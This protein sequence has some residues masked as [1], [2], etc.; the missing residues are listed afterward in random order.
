MPVSLTPLPREIPPPTSPPA[1]D[2]QSVTQPSI[3]RRIRRD[4]LLL[5]AGN[6]AVLIA[7]LG[8]R[9]ILI[10]ALTPADY[11]R[12]ALVLSIYNTV[13]IIGASGLPNSVA[14]YIAMNDSTKDSAIIRSAIL[15]G[16]GPIAAAAVGIACVSGILLH[17]SLAFVFAPIGLSALVYSLLTMG[18][19]R[20]RGR[21]GAAAAIMPIAAVGEVV[22]LTILWLSRAGVTPL[23]AFGVFCL[24]NVVGLIAGIFFTRRTAPHIESG[25]EPSTD[26]VPSPGSLLRFA[27]W[28]GAAT[29]GVAILPVIMRAAAAL[30]SYTVVAIIDV[31]LVLFA[32]PQRLG[33]V[34][35]LAV[36][37]HASRDLDKTGG[38]FVISRREHAI[39]IVPFVI[40]AMIVAFTPIVG[41]LFDALGRPVY[42]RSSDYLALALL[43]GPARILYGVVEGVL[44]AHGEGRFLAITALSIAALASG[45]I[46]AIAAL[47]GTL[48]AFAVFAASFWG[49]YLVG[50]A[51]VRRL[52]NAA[53]A[54]AAMTA[55]NSSSI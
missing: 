38:G 48:L 18:I 20:G 2:A 33:T 27:I 35:V 47:T 39:T 9:S 17:S 1:V 49:V 24:G 36:V 43:A 51:R 22:P 25:T 41:W 29:I 52:T 55:H 53:Q 6:V 50:L 12:L 4:V 16:A 10:T 32:I 8:F 30:D 34:I 40:A 7:Q 45:L 11:G 15:A 14:R 28:L 46:F 21:M 44:V 42:G 5:G 37:P 26:G 23:S 13:W 31:A 54:G 3:W 19:L